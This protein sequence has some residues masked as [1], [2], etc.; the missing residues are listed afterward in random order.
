LRR[1]SNFLGPMPGIWVRLLMEE[2]PPWVVR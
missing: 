2:K 1:D